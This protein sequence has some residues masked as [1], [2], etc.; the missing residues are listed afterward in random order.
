MIIHLTGCD[1]SGKT[2]IARELNKLIKDAK[3]VHFSNPKHLEDGKKQYFDFIDKSK[4]GNYICD[5]LHDGEWVYAP[6]Y[7]NYVANYMSEFENELIKNHN[8]LLVYV[9]A[10]LETIINRTRIRGEDFVKEEHFQLVLDNFKNNY[11]MNQ[12]MPFTIIDTTS[13]STECNVKKAYDDIERLNTI[14]DKVRNTKIKGTL[15]P[16]SLPRGNINGGYM[17][18]GQNPGGRGKLSDEFLPIWCKGTT[19]GFFTNILKEKG[20]YLDCWFTNLVLSST[21]DNKITKKQVEESIDTLQLQLDVIKPKVIIALGKEVSKYM[22]IYFPKLDIIEIP[23][24]SYIKRF[25]AGKQ[26]KI[27][28]YKSLFDKIKL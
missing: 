25:F 5:R 17:I 18:V 27:E 7:R 22:N 11:L 28:K 14:W 6:I 15:T 24:P 26:N 16:T 19:S 12:N 1:G 9:T 23:H 13:S 8:Y 2:T 4:N 10:S 3:Y 21:I 20:I